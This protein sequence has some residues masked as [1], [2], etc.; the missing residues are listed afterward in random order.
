MS[1]DPLYIDNEEDDG[2]ALGAFGIDKVNDLADQLSNVLADRMMAL[3]PDISGTMT[4][5]THDG[6]TVAV[7]IDKDGNTTITDLESGDS[8][9]GNVWDSINGDIWYEEGEDQ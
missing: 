4:M 9:G 6:G 5:P 1:D 3:R 8:C 2:E 7:E